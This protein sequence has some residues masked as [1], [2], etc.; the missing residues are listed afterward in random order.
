PYVGKSSLFRV[1]SG[2]VTSDAH[3]VNAT[4]GATER[5]SNPHYQI[6][7]EAVATKAVVAG[8]IASVTKLETVGT[9]DTL[10][11]PE[12]RVALPK[13][14]LPSPLYFAAITPQAQADL[15]KMG[16][17]LAR[18]AEEDPSLHVSRS[19]HT[20]ETILAAFGESHVQISLERIRRKFGANLKADVP[21]VA[22]RETIRK[23]VQAHGRHK[24][25]TGGHG[26]FGD[27][28]V[29]FEP[30]ARG[31]G[32]VFEDRVVGGRVPRNF[33]PSVEKGLAE[34]IGHGLLAGYPVVD[35]KAALFDGSYHQVDSSDEAFRMAARLAYQEGYAKAEPVLLE[36]IIKLAITIPDAFTGDVIGDISGKRGHVLGMNAAAESGM[37]TVEVEVPEAEVQRYATDLRSITQGRGV[38]TRAFVRYQEV[39][40]NVQEKLVAQAAAK[41][42]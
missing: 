20:G 24:R 1:F 42:G 32:F 33:I 17:A 16:A 39:P 35:M 38:F 22:Y 5:I 27:V 23:K 31:S 18:I 11:S 37:T 2:T 40:G 6:G 26:Q 21:Q 14:A 19:E 28:H 34:A 25:Q 9:G 3:L 36:P 7:K 41:K 4:T 30:L 15:D 29:E 13:F 10:T 8:D 12:H